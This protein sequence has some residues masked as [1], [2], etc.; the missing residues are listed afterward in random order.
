MQDKTLL[1]R[2]QGRFGQ[3][4]QA[5]LHQFSSESKDI[6]VEVSNSDEAMKNEQSPR[7]EGVGTGWTTKCKETSKPTAFP[8]QK[9]YEKSRMGAGG[10]GGRK[11][12]DKGHRTTASATVGWTGGHQNHTIKQKCKR[13]KQCY[14]PK[15]RGNN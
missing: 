14:R 11:L 2:T 1:Q 5:Y 3:E 8:V 13:K 6:T 4:I 10:K 15:I 9:G 7:A 12:L